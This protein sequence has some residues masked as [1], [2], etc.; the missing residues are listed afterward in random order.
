MILFIQVLIFSSL[1]A[2]NF[3]DLSA[4]N[5]VELWWPKREKIFL[6]SRASFDPQMAYI[7]DLRK[8]RIADDL[9][10]M[11]QMPLVFNYSETVRQLVLDYDE[12]YEDPFDGADLNLD[13]R[14]TN[15]LIA[16][17]QKFLGCLQQ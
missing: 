13:S 2:A 7:F 16:T 11:R 9:D 17:I 4:D 10:T 5:I 1:Q 6:E 15:N 8:Q 3:T 12:N 14:K